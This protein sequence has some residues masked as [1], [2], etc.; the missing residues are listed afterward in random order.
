MPS[1]LRVLFGILAIVGL[2]LALAGAFLVT[3]MEPVW[4]DCNEDGQPGVC[5][6]GQL[7]FMVGCALLVVGCAMLVVA[8]ATL[9]DRS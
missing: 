2:M 9:W 1:G 7:F 4:T 5:R 8:V 6:L 3:G